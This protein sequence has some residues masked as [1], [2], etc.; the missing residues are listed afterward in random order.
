MTTDLAQDPWIYLIDKVGAM[1]HKDVPAGIDDWFTFVGQVYNGG[2]TQYVI[3]GHSN[4]FRKAL[5]F[6]RSVGSDSAWEFAGRMEG[7]DPRPDWEEAKEAAEGPG[8]DPESWDAFEDWMYKRNPSPV[9][10]A[11]KE[12]LKKLDRPDEIGHR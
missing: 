2:I 6:I 8:E 4:G 12:I 10:E 1:P 7:L 11:A 5:Q 3:N 9:D